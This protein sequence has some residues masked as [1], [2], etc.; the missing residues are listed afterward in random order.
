MQHSL[1]KSLAARFLLV[2]CIIGMAGFVAF[3]FYHGLALHEA[4]STIVPASRILE[5]KYLTDLPSEEWARAPDMS[6]TLSEYALVTVNPAAFMHDADTDGEMVVTIRTPLLNTED[7]VR[8]TLVP[9]L[10]PISMDAVLVVTNETGEF[11]EPLPPLKMYR[12]AVSGWLPS[13]ATFTVSDTVLLGQIAAGGRIYYLGQTGPNLTRGGEV[14]H[15]L[16]RSDKTIPF[17]GL[18]EEFDIHLVSGCSLMNLDGNRSHTILIRLLNATHTVREEVV[19]LGAGNSTYPVILSSFEPGMNSARFTVDGN[20]ASELE[21][22]DACSGGFL[23]H[24]NGT[25][26]QN[27]EIVTR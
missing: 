26:T 7:R 10:P 4:P 20:R 2:S 25:V 8:I 16:Y 13:E 6:G 17:R 24:P 12:G 3:I 5:M 22:A 21:L 11:T 9:V 18:P 14:I 27:K 1:F 23:I 15:I 19:E